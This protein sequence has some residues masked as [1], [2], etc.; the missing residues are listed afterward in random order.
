CAASI[1]SSLA[2]F[3]PP[4]PQEPS[5]L[6]DNHQAEIFGLALSTKALQG[7]WM[8][9]YNSEEDGLSFNRCVCVCINM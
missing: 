8:R 9:I 5:Y 6:L 1:P 4:R 2:V 3:T 7:P